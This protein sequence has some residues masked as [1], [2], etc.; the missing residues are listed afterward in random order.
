LRGHPEGP[1]A[2][3]QMLDG[4]GEEHRRSS[5]RYCYNAGS[6]GLVEGT[7]YPACKFC[8]IFFCSI[9]ARWPRGGPGALSQG[10]RERERETKAIEYH[11][12]NLAIFFLA[13]QSCILQA[14][15][16]PPVQVPGVCVAEPQNT[17]WHD[18]Q[19]SA[20]APSINVA[21]CF[22]RAR[23]HIPGTGHHSSG[24]RPC[25]AHAAVPPAAIHLEGHFGNCSDSTRDSHLAS[26]RL[27][28][29]SNLVLT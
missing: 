15:S 2:V 12:Q 6:V 22:N 28:K 19:F 10:E 24:G 14:P 26:V 13:E 25:P 18:P 29:T 16:V 9:I 8:M 20:A 17:S 11:T 5:L 4:R 27:K 23:A 21:R 1:I 3:S 7:G